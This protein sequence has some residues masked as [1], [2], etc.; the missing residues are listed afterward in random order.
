MVML[1]FAWWCRLRLMFTR[2]RR[3]TER[4]LPHP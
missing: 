2:R 1:G 3:S 4:P